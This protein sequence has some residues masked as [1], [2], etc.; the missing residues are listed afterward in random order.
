MTKLSRTQALVL[1][2]AAQWPLTYTVWADG[3]TQAYLELP[4]GI[5]VVKSPTAK[6]LLER[7][8]LAQS[9]NEHDGR[10]E[11]TAAGHEAL[12]E[13]PTGR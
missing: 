7:G 13:A 8:L 4:N 6:G 12:A 5:Q 9:D 2:A 3:F 1:A 11:V 10:L